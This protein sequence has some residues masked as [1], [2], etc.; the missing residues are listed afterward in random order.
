MARTT[1]HVLG[2]QRGKIGEVVGHI[3]DGVQIYTAHTD[4]V[5]N[6]RTPK[7]VA[8]RACF[9]AV[10]GLGRSLGSSIR[11]GFGNEAAKHKLTSPFNIFVHRNMPASSYDPDTHTVSV[12]YQEVSVAC[13][14]TPFVGFS[15]AN[16]TEAL[17]VSAAFTP[18]SD[19][20]GADDT[21]SVYL[22]VYIPD[23]GMSATAVASRLDGTVTATLPS[24]FGGRTAHVWGFV[25]TSVEDSLFIEA[26]GTLLVPG[27]CSSSFYLG[28]GTIL[29]A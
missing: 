18:Y 20:P 28:T 17:K 14:T 26:S 23:L 9:T 13:G 1:K 6:P 24:V 21:D 7:Q 12:N 15:S 3:V 27:E 10:T 22:V 16:F 25:R 29:S 2:N 8:H 5:H 11:L 19:T 4:A